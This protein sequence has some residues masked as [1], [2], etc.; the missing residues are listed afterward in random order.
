MFSKAK[1]FRAQSAMEYL[2]TYGWAILIIAI[3]LGALFS[4]GVFSSGSFVGTTC[5]PASGYECSTVTFHSGTFTATVGQA[6]GTTW[7]TANIV[8]VTGGAVPSTTLPTGG[9]CTFAIAGGWTS[10]GS[11]TATFTAPYASGSA[12]S[13]TLLSTTVGATYSGTLWALYT[14]SGVTG[15]Q[16]TQIATVTLKAS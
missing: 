12:C 4:L 1:N 2:M 11:T 16:E 8:F 10:G 15:V 6:T 5:I 7:T 14:T 9:T 13:A 3:V